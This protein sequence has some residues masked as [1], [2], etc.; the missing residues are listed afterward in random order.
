MPDSIPLSRS[1]ERA[2]AAE[3]IHT[4]TTQP[5]IVNRRSTALLVAEILDSTSWAVLDGAGV[6]RDSARA[7]LSALWSTQGSV[8]GD[9]QWC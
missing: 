4:S 2:R 8:G 1:A 9:T 6:D 5:L 7:I 3:M